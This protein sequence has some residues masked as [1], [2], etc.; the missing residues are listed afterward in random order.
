MEEQNSV[1]IAVWM[2]KSK[3][4]LKSAQELLR[5]I[6]FDKSGMPQDVS[7]GEK[8]VSLVFAGQYSAGKSTILKALTGIND[9]AIG[10]GITTQKAHA[11][12]WNGIE[13]IDT[14]GIHT[15]LYPDHD[16]ISYQAIANAD[17]LVYVVTHTTR[18][19]I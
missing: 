8:P 2:A 16:E 5:K 15:T 10:T 3:K 13:V 6:G 17:M 11:Y 19:L 18:P 14:P 4:L 7:E 1:S 9:I 12:D